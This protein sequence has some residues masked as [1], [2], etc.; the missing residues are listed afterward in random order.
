MGAGD[1]R[2]RWRPV[3]G[4]C[5][6]HLVGELGTAEGEGRVAEGKGM[7]QRGRCAVSAKLRTAAATITETGMRSLLLP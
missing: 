1:K 2:G 5:G 3:L 6:V 4:G 7:H